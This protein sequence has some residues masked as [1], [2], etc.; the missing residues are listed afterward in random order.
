M[1]DNSNLK[2][3]RFCEEYLVDLNATKAAI[4]CGYSPRSAKTQ[5]SRLLADDDIKRKIAELRKEQ[6]IRTGI[7]ADRVIN[8]LAKIGFSDA[9]KAIRIVKGKVRVTNTADLDEDTRA[10]ISSISQT[11]TL[12]GGSIGIKFH[13]KKGSLELLGKHLGIFSD[14]DETPDLPMPTVVQV[15]V[16]NA[17]KSA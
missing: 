5:G 10:A 1:A 11:I 4:R 16:V 7:T 15:N 2:R 8:E 6:S 17:R 9:T 3:E 14:E 13:D 12:N